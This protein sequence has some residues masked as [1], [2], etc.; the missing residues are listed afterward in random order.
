MTIISG[1]PDDTVQAC[2]DCDRNDY[3]NP[4]VRSY[5]AAAYYVHGHG[6][7]HFQLPVPLAVAHT[8]RLADDYDFEAA[9]LWQFDE[10][11]GYY[12]NG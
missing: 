10:F 1:L 12:Y 8:M 7:P 5:M 3:G 4:T 2:R 11:Y 9:A 6:A